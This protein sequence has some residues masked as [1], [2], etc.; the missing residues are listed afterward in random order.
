MP[1]EAPSVSKKQW[2]VQQNFNGF[3]IGGHDDD[4]AN[5]PIQRLG[6][7]IGALFGLL[8]IGGLLDQI[9]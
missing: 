8:V 6:G 1:S 7:F 5:A 3:G 4:F 2:Q 9:Q